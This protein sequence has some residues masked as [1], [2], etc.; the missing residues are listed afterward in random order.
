MGL[1]VYE[2]LKQYF[3]RLRDCKE[4][5]VCIVRGLT[6]FQLTLSSDRPND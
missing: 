6:G 2:S 4:T 3:E 1:V 5:P